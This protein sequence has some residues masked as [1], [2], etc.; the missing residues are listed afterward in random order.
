MKN[1]LKPL[2]ALESLVLA[3]A[4][5]ILPGHA[6][7]A[8]SA[9][10]LAAPAAPGEGGEDGECFTVLVGKK[11]SA[12]GAVMVAHN[13]DD[14]GAIIVN[15]RRIRGRDGGSVRRVDLGKGAVH[16]TDSRTNGFLWI[17]ATT[18]EFADSFVNEHGV[19]V[20]SDS[21]PSRALAE[22]FTDG[23][24]GWMLRRMMAEKAGSA[25]EAVRLAGE[26]VERYGYRSSGRTYS[27][28]DR[29]E[30][31]MLAILRGRR[32]YAQRVPDDEVAVIPN[33]Y[34][35]RRIR[36]GDAEN[37]MG[38]PDI[39]EYAARNGWYDPARDGE[40]DFKKAFDRPSSRKPAEDGNVLRHWRGLN[41]VTGREWP[42]DGDY[43]F[44]AKPARK[45][46]AAGLMAIMR[47]HYEG[48]EYD[49]TNGYRT[50]TPN[51]T[52][53]RTICT[54]STISSFVVS[55][56]PDIPEPLAAAVWLAFGKPDTTIYV[57]LY[58][59]VGVLPPAA[60]L[61]SGT[62]DDAVMARQHFEDGEFQA[63]KA[64]L[65]NTLVLELEKAAEGDY[66]NAHRRIAR[67]LFPAERS[68]LRSQPKFEK[69]FAALYAKDKAGAQKLLDDYVAA[70]FRKTAGLTG[71][72]LGR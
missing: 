23:G 20:T 19:A 72:L 11:A 59:G 39:A 52:R 7:P 29:N 50:G 22:D 61:G 26:L 56:R 44:S 8:G 12:D 69:K 53:F 68:F 15:V 24:I 34:T 47:D 46:T 48:T 45:V 14:R 40:F 28:A 21:C 57:P 49:A 6:A 41:L 71:R 1:A 62:P 18:Q 31:W 43:P 42:L 17:E 35:I 64:G 66:G 55:L 38:S 16:E 33:Y 4:L 37:F 58:Y 13:E 30:A 25:R 60:G 63:A 27:I 51:R 5:L 70:A 2:A 3:I 67:R 32:W 54:A 10:I 9:P 65:L 36:P